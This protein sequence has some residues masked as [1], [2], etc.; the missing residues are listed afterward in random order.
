[1]QALNE[2]KQIEKTIQNLL[3]LGPPAHEVIVIDGGSTD[4]CC[5]CHHVAP[6]GDSKSYMPFL[7]PSMNREGL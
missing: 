5:L 4:R 6:S 1:M 7:M 3:Y 2:E